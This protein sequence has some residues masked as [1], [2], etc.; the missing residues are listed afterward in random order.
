MALNK[1]LSDLKKIVACKKTTAVGDVVIAGMNNGVVYGI[2]QDIKPN[3]KRDWWDI[4]FTALVIPPVD[5]TWIL[6]MPQM[7]GE[8]FTIHGEDH[9][10]FAVD[11]SPADQSR[12][13]S[14]SK[15]GLSIVKKEA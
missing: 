15:P 8:L 11:I 3:I 4:R 14:G 7:T 13:P 5:I 12:M 6:R 10:L 9:F 1:L 2:V